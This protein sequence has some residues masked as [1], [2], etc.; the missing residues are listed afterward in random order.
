M[1]AEH[2][3]T[4]EQVGE[5][6]KVHFLLLLHVGGTQCWGCYTFMGYLSYF[7]N[8]LD[9]CTGPFSYVAA[10]FFAWLDAIV[11][12]WSFAYVFD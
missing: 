5:S 12:L 7:S 11:G 9:S 2:H 8:L 10:S 6:Y 1:A 4:A 3:W